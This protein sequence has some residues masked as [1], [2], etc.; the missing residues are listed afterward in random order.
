MIDRRASQG[1]SVAAGPHWE[2]S[3]GLRPAGAR[4]PARLWGVHPGCGVI[5][6]WSGT[7]R[8]VGLQL[9][10]QALLQALR[11][12][13]LGPEPAVLWACSCGPYPHPY[14]APPL[15]EATW[16]HVALPRTAEPGGNHA[17]KIRVISC[18]VCLFCF[19]C[20]AVVFVYLCR[21]FV[22]F[23]YIVFKFGFSPF[24]FP[25]CFPLQWGFGNFSLTFILVSCCYLLFF[26]SSLFFLFLPFNFSPFNFSL[27]FMSYIVA[28]FSLSFSFI[29]LF[30]F[31][32]FSHLYLIL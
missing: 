32:S 15:T 11:V 5:G 7:V 13:G 27:I 10:G 19:W 16:L 1:R 21:F 9:K 20:V 25:S 30:L 4:P 12:P 26:F 24:S 17:C 18:S 22:S 29:F 14:P 2:P 3:Q 6:C 8:S 31:S 23:V 28:S